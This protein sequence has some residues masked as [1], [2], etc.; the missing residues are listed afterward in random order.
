MGIR[1]VVLACVTDVDDMR[2]AKRLD[3]MS[4]ACMMPI[5]QVQPPREDLIRVVLG[6]LSKIKRL[7][8]RF[9]IRFSTYG[10]GIMF[11]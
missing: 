1:E 11:C 8:L 4:I 5:A 9:K 3:D 7:G 2:D 10:F 6:V